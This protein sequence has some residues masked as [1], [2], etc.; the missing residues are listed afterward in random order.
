MR[1]ELAALCLIVILLWGLWAFLY[2]LGAEKL[3]LIQAL[4]CACVVGAICSVCIAGFLIFK[5]DALQTGDLKS[6]AII[7][8]AT[9]FG[10]LG[11]IIWY[12]SIYK[13]QAS[14]VVPFTALYPLVTVLLGIFI[15]RENIQPINAIGILLAL[16]AC[17][18]LSL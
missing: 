7:A 6:Y 3:N 14:I 9:V 18:L 4:F 2:K 11:T 1:L 16:I 12:L 17:F 5:S 13:Y 15:L 10:A 8:L